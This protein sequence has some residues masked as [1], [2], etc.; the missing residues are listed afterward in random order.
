VNPLDFAQ[1]MQNPVMLPQGNHINN[2]P[3]HS[4]ESTMDKTQSNNYRTVGAVKDFLKATSARLSASEKFSIFVERAEGYHARITALSIIQSNETKG[5]TVAA[6]AA[7]EAAIERTTDLSGVLGVYAQSISDTALYEKSKLKKSQID[8]LRQDHQFLAAYT[9]CDL[10]TGVGDSLK[11]FLVKSE[12]IDEC[13][14]TIDRAAQAYSV[15]DQ[16][17]RVRT[18]ACTQMK[19]EFRL[20]NRMI[21]KELTPFLKQYFREDPKL[22]IEWDNARTIK[23]LGI[24]HTKK[25]DPAAPAQPENGT[26]PTPAAQS[27]AVNGTQ[28][29]SVVQYGATNGTQPTSTV[30]SGSG[31]GIEATPVLHNGAGNGTMPQGPLQAPV[32]TNGNG[33]S[34]VG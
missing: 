17:A 19:E 29:T 31:N 30:Q 8:R 16:A 5:L 13:R 25:E 34:S 27:G 4:L 2:H 7:M 11:P 10:A 33:A 23:N 15:R 21:S 26:Q 1:K 14:A 9:V 20:F 22:K 24:R 12:M 18:T 32:P 28:A 6:E 3:S